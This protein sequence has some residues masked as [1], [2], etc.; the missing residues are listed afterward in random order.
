MGK[1]I[2]GATLQEFISDGKG[3]E[4]KSAVRKEVKEAPPLEVKPPEVVLPVDED[5][6]AFHD[7]DPETVDEISKSERFRKAIGKKHRAMREAQEE[8]RDAESFAKE[9][10]NRARLSD[11]RAS[12]LESQLKEFQKSKPAEPEF[13]RP[14]P[15]DVKYLDE[16]KQF[17]AFAYAEDLASY[18]AQKAVKDENERLLQARQEAERQQLNAT[19]QERLQEA[20]KAHKDWDE[21]VP[22]D[23]ETG[24]RIHQ[25]VID[26]LPTSKNVGELLYYFNTH[27]EEVERI[28]KLSPLAAVAE[29][30]RIELTFEKPQVSNGTNAAP[31][32]PKVSGAPAPIAPISASRTVNINVD[33]A[34]MSFKELREFERNRHRRR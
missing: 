9:Q 7:P 4:I 34:K 20:R 31:E 30:G 5:P 27:P 15:E 6:E 26:Y 14:N 28:N 18:S 1:V 10:W 32:L 25:S 22:S 12:S 13:K 33:P 17:K 2:T 16:N 19:V 3:Q 24:P 11:E 29:V 8:A 23:P 21:K